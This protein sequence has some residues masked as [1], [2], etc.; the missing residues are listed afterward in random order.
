MKLI[1]IV[2]LVTMIEAA[3]IPD[4]H[5]VHSCRT[6]SLSECR[7]LNYSTVYPNEND[8]NVFHR[9]S[10]VF[11]SGCSEYA[12]SLACF[13]LEP[14]CHV[15]YFP[16][17]TTFV[18]VGHVCKEFCLHVKNECYE[19]APWWHLDCDTLP[20][21]STDGHCF[22]P[23]AV[24]LTSSTD[25]TPTTE[26]SNSTSNSSGTNSSPTPAA[27]P[28]TRAPI[29]CPG[30]LVPYKGKSFGSI[31][32]CTAPCHFYYEDDVISPDTIT[33]LFTAW[34]ILAL[35]SV[36][37][38]VSFLLTWK[39]YSHIEYPYYC[40]YLCHGLFIVAFLIRAIVGHDS[41]VC[42]KQY[43]T[44]NDSALCTEKFGNGW[45]V[46]TFLFTYYVTLAIGIWIV[47]MSIALCTLK[48]FKWRYHLHACYHIAAWGIPFIFCMVTSFLRF[49]SGD[50][51][52]GICQI[53]PKHS[54]WILIFPLVVC[55]LLGFVVFL[56]SI[57]QMFFC[58]RAGRELQNR[59]PHMVWRSIVFGT[60][61]LVELAVLIVLHLIEH[62]KH[63][64][65]EH[66]YT[67]CVIKSP[68]NNDCSTK[69]FNRPTY[70]IPILRFTLISVVGAVSVACPLSRKVTWLSWKES[71]QLLYKK[72]VDL[73]SRCSWRRKTV[74]IVQLVS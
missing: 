32:D 50:S 21:N 66:Y 67:D 25:A 39:H 5:A 20:S 28:A 43:S 65:W 4:H 35:L 38:L 73:F 11:N 12:L 64:D 56:M 54:L 36:V 19:Y 22:I 53:D 68:P 55:F 71:L 9:M 47:N 14:N 26:P 13:M 8:L 7:K 44:N 49:S 60:I 27:T 15:H 41:V 23:P 30:R 34:T 42:D 48:H 29:S 33:G 2:S 58:S 72:I 37:S 62:V 52:L 69:S 31:D 6:V 51:L 59:H 24:N 61:L 63:S 46:V 18:F 3:S 74:V 70:V 45:C 17:N 1:L 16:D 57:I 40:A 10:D